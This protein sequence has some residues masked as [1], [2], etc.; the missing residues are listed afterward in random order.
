MNLPDS[1]SYTINVGDALHD[2]EETF[3][4]RPGLLCHP[5]FRERI[6][7]V[8]EPGHGTSVFHVESRALA[9][10]Y[11]KTGT[12][13]PRNLRKY[14]VPRYEPNSREIFQYFLL[15]SRE[16]LMVWQYLAQL[17]ERQ[18]MGGAGPL[19]TRDAH[20]TLLF[21]EGIGRE[22]FLIRVFWH[23]SL[24]D[25]CWSIRAWSFQERVQ[26]GWDPFK[27]RLLLPVR[28]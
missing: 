4:N 2:P 24:G 15:Q 20:A 21:M 28:V 16:L 23:R 27:N 3:S 12:R 19:A 7:P 8:L 11:D 9:P 26:R 25:G 5:T 1:I 14:V 18:P 6:L 10:L 22:V 17:L 13:Y